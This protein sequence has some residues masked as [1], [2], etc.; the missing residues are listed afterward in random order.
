MARTVT[1]RSPRHAE[2]TER[3]RVLHFLRRFTPGPTAALMDEVSAQGIRAWLD[4]QLEG[5]VAPPDPSGPLARGLLGLRSLGLSSRE[6]MAE[7][8]KP[9][10]DGL[11]AEERAALT[12]L[13]DV[14]GRELRDS[15]LLRAVHGPDPVRE[16]A[17]DFFRNHLC[18][19]VD[20]GTV[21]YLATSY[22]R[23][24]IRARVFGSFR[25]LLGASA[26]HPAMLVY[27]DNHLSRRPPTKAELKEIELQERQRT[28]SKELG[29][30]ASD[31]AAQR[32]LN[33]NYAREL[34]ELHTLGADNH[35]TQADVEEVAR[36][37]TGWTIELDETKPLDFA[38]RAEMHCGGDKKVLHRVI[39]ESWKEPW[40]E[41]EQVLDLLAEHRGTADFLA[42]KLCKHF[43]RDDPGP[44]LVARV[45]AAFRRG[46]GDLSTVYRAIADDPEFFAPENYGAKFKRPF[47]FVVS[48]LR[49]TGA[50]VEDCERLHAALRTMSEE[51]YLC[52]DPTGYYDQAEAWL[53]PGAL[54]A[55]WKFAR[56]LADGRVR[57]VSLPES[58]YGDLE[59]LE[60]SEAKAALVSLLL[61]GGAR[62][63]T[64]AVLDA[65]VADATRRKRLGPTLVGAI[66][67][68]P[69]FQEQ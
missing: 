29:R 16:A 51:L 21:A 57:G 55:R 39:R 61:P 5:R 68:S 64:S 19:A 40:A 27:L 41:G 30:E 49:A 12:K 24:V 52:K 26:R 17:A 25:D 45:A 66:L 67:G 44:D 63:R 37:L 1:R 9:V 58:L 62:A 6:I 2:L 15:V 11:P 20:K 3:E 13:R 56:D 32:G 38:F 43:V 28:K 4:D 36:A 34:L 10:P 54:A 53:D 14:P 59:G 8:V 31:I 35:Y 22:E 60:P 46:K 42:W 69:E 48:A 23:D 47:E 7:Y 33:E 18:V 65:L 50:V